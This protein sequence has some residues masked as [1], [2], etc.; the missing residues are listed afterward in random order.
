MLYM[1]YRASQNFQTHIGESPLFQGE[2]NISATF[3]F[4]VGISFRLR[5]SDSKQLLERERQQA[6]LSAVLLFLSPFPSSPCNAFISPLRKTQ[7][8]FFQL[9]RLLC[10]YQLLTFCPKQSHNR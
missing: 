7:G 6:Q 2:H 9:P 8:T 5:F 4:D 3:Q 1:I 10:R